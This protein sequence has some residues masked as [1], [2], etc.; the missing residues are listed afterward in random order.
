MVDPLVQVWNI[1]KVCLL[2]QN[3]NL[4]KIHIFADFSP[5]THYFSVKDSGIDDG[6]VQQMVEYSHVPF[7]AFDTNVLLLILAKV[8]IHD[9]SHM[10]LL[11]SIALRG[12]FI[13]SHHLINT[14]ILFLVYLQVVLPN[15]FLKNKFNNM[16]VTSNYL[17]SL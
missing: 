16:Y 1:C 11:S 10:C 9:A 7:S 3:E 17:I 2:I 8:R 14:E 5:F 6:N 4:I 15:F 13:V 12:P